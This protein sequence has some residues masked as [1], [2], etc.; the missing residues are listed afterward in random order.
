MR[1]ASSPARMRACL[2]LFGAG[3]LLA[4]AGSW[5]PSDVARAAPSESDAALCRLPASS[6]APEALIRALVRSAE[7][8]ARTPPAVLVEIRDNRGDTRRILA[9][10]DPYRAGSAPAGETRRKRRGDRGDERRRD[11]PRTG[12]W[13]VLERNDGPASAR[14]ARRQARKLAHDGPP[15]SYGL[16]ARYLAG[17]IGRIQVLDPEE[18]DGARPPD[19]PRWR[20]E[21]ERLGP[22]S[23]MLKGEDLSSLV[24]GTLDVACD[25][26]G[27]HVVRARLRLRHPASLGW[28]VSIRDGRADARFGRDP[29]GRGILLEERLAVEVKPFLFSAFRYET[30]RRYRD[31]RFPEREWESMQERVQEPARKPTTTPD[32]QTGM[33]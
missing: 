20:I 18:K 27:P 9:R 22:G 19:A 32:G 25:A 17:E 31:H 6:V 5:H 12:G 28:L 24:A 8:V 7:R 11:D 15:G 21:I 10:Y 30:T 23:L 3:L 33:P 4:L 16:I 29:R 1:R 2:R 13:R 26:H 14:V